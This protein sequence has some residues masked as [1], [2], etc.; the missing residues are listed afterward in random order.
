MW[1]HVFYAKIFEFRGDVE[2]I[3]KH[4]MPPSN[5][6]RASELTNK[7]NMRSHVLDLVRRT[8]AVLSL[9]RDALFINTHLSLW[10]EIVLQLSFGQIPQF[11]S[12][13]LLD[14]KEV[15]P[16]MRLNMLKI[17]GFLGFERFIRLNL[18]E[19]L[20]TCYLE[21]YADLCITVKNLPWPKSPKLIYTASNFDLDEVFKVWAANKVLEGA[22]YFVGQH[23]A[24]Y[25]THKY[26]QTSHMPEQ[27][28]VDKFLT[29]GWND[30]T[31]NKVP[32]F[33]F[34]SLNLPQRKKTRNGGLLL[35]EA[36]MLH[37]ITHWDNYYEFG[38]YQEEQF[39]FI[40]AL[41]EAIQTQ[42]TIRLH[43]SFR[44]FN[45]SDIERMRDHNER[46]VISDGKVSVSS[47]IKNSRLVVFAY[48]STGFLECLNLNIP[49]I[50]FWQNGF[51]HLLPD[52]VA[53]YQAL[54]DAGLIYF[55]TEMAANH[56][57]KVWDNI[58]SWWMSEKIQN[59]RLAFCEHY[60]R[61]STK[62]IHDLKEIL[63]NEK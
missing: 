37:Q 34:N 29:W 38:L 20:P 13:P 30:N 1:N 17:E 9:D 5:S 26:F 31:E 61:N 18:Q 32:A 35:I 28:A 15:N 52:A 33:I 45:W 3:K 63:L 56:V 23:G 6:L 62:P 19:A 59:V 41:P 8:L 48:D 53:H 44:R 14:A 4:P 10:R 40:S 49:V 27:K 12:S 39:K 25:G 50:A 11:W 2:I 7:K 42:T 57:L 16:S 22:P 36:S 46:V 21:G 24:G 43:R 58:E 60:A 51:A 54:L 47:Q 55:D